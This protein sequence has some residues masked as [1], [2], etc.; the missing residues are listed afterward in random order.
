MEPGHVNSL[1]ESKE[2][3]SAYLGTDRTNSSRAELRKNEN[4][5]MVAASNAKAAESE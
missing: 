1:N 5:P 2:P 4:D 3:I